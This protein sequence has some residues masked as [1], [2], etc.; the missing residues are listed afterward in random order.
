MKRI[1]IL[2]SVAEPSVGSKE[3]PEAAR[4]EL[5][6]LLH[7]INVYASREE[8]RIILSGFRF[9]LVEINSK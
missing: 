1:K 8:M 4:I 2:V 7:D 5:G 9:I 3:S 6:M